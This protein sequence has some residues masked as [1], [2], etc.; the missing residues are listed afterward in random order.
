MP[1]KNKGIDDALINNSSIEEISSEEALNQLQPK[2][3]KVLTESEINDLIE[4]YNEEYAVSFYG[5]RC[6]IIREVKD[7]KSI[8]MV[9]EFLRK[10]D[11][12][13]HQANKKIKIKP[14]KKTKTVSLAK[15]WFE[16]RDRR[17]YDKV[18]FDPENSNPCHYNLWKG[19]AVEPVEGTCEKYLNHIRNIIC[20]RNDELYQYV[21][22]WMAHAVQYPAQRPETALVLQGGQGTGKGFFVNAFGSLFGVHYKQVSQSKHLVGN[23]NSHLANTLVLFADEAFWAGD[24]QGENTLKAL[25]T[26]PEIAIEPKGRDVFTTPNRLR[27][28]MASNEDWV[29]PANIDDRRFVVLQVSEERKQDNGYFAELKMELDDGG[30]EAFLHFLLTYDISNFNLRSIPKTDA[31]LEQKIQSLEAVDR[32]VYDRLMEGQWLDTHDGWNNE[33]AKH[34]LYQAYCEASSIAGVRRRNWEGQFAKEI[35]KIIPAV[36]D[37]RKTVYNTDGFGNQKQRVVYYVFPDLSVCRQSFEQYIGSTIQ[38]SPIDDDAKPII[39]FT[40]DEDESI[41]DEKYENDIFWDGI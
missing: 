12:I 16:H 14:A 6:V 38:W 21:L 19:F 37:T 34:D 24:K 18:V 7:G 25:I 1:E 39:L 35:S 30:S 15:Y 22:A 33:I 40:D 11:L 13:D 9:P 10:Q 36:R 26:E 17:T 23:F 3:N 31:L 28:I 2:S 29:V 5:S 4:K 20:N 32:F 8:A 41:D 27:I